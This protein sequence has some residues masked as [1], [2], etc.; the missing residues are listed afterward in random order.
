M[1]FEILNGLASLCITHC[2]SFNVYS[3]TL[4]SS[5]A[6]FLNVPKITAKEMGN[7]VFIVFGSRL[8]SSYVSERQPHCED[9]EMTGNEGVWD[10]TKVPGWTRTGDIVF[11]GRCL[12]HGCIKENLIH[13]MF[14]DGAPFIYSPFIHMKVAHWAHTPKKPLLASSRFCFWA[15][16]A[17]SLVLLQ[18]NQLRA[19]TSKTLIKLSLLNYRIYFGKENNLFHNEHYTMGPGSIDSV[20]KYM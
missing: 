1:V 3:H 20:I 19:Y 13:T 4:R 12:N 14:R 17:C 2:L 15:H 5:A 7:A 9:R 18:L 16:R 8:R 11:F 6:C 10:A